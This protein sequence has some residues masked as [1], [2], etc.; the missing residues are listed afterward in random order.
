METPTMSDN[1]RRYRVICHAL[2]PASPTPP[3]G[4][5]ARHWQTL[6]ALISGIVGGKSTQ[7]PHIATKVPDG[8]KPESRIKRFARW[9]DNE[10]ILEE[11]YFVPYADLLLTQ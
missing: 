10:R 2:T 4:H 11:A 5:F 1:L 6:A 8:R 9:R 7:R 3:T